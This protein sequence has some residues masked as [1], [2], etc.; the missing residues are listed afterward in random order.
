MY[1]LSRGIQ[2]ITGGHPASYLQTSKFAERL[3]S[4]SVYTTLPIIVNISQKVRERD[5]ASGEQK[6]REGRKG[7]VRFSLSKGRGGGQGIKKGK[8]KISNPRQCGDLY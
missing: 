2:V 3:R 5:K 8:G 4:R 7:V 6:E 1:R